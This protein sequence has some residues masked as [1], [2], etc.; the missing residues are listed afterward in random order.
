ME[1]LSAA[2]KLLMIEPTESESKETLDGFAESMIKIAKEAE[3][4][5]EIVHT[6]PHDTEIKRPMKH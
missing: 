4:N 6:A 3:T 5:P 2:S 1:R